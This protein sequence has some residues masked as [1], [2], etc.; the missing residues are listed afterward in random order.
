[1]S[2]LDKLTPEL[3][4]RVM[5]GEREE[6]SDGEESPGSPME[7]FLT[8]FAFR[9]GRVRTCS[10]SSDPPCLGRT[11]EVNLVPFGALYI[12]AYNCW[13]CLGCQRSFLFQLTISFLRLSKK[14]GHIL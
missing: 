13:H 4:Q 8:F 9:K 11:L 2:R 14:F 10:S 12:H 1:M 5:N 7:D 3:L 6:N